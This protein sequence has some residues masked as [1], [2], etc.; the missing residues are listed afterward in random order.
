M[1]VSAY[2][3][4]YNNEATLEKCIN[5]IKGQSVPVDELFIVDDDSSDS[6]A[7]IA[8]DEGVRIVTM[9]CNQGRGAVRKKA[10]E[11]A[12]Y[13]FVLCCDATLELDSE[14]IEKGL[15]YL[16]EERIVAVF[17]KV[18][19]RIKKTVVD[20]WRS[21]YLFKEYNHFNILHNI[22][23]LTGGAILKKKP[24]LGVGN[25]DATLR[26]SEDS[27]LGSRLNNA[28]F[29]TVS[30]STMIMYSMTNDGLMKTMERYWRWHVGVEGNVSIKVYLKNIWFSIRVM[31]Y[32]DCCDW[33]F[34]RALIS[35]MFPHILLFMTIYNKI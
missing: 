3:P 17:G 6:T 29:D 35:L 14:F 26:H 5:S 13:E 20:R 10:M 24:V 4:C 25:F 32:Q 9:N 27:D 15:S 2:I 31:V 34:G 22:G 23:L 16:Q 30:D 33:D 1:K 19:Q 7:D 8:R 21:I 11:V 28:G 12:K 18:R